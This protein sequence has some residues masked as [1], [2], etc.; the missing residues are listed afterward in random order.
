LLDR[1][2][3]LSGPIAS[4]K[5]TLANR[6]VERFGFVRLSS[7]NLILVLKP[8]VPQE[9]LA[10]QEAGD[11][12]DRETQGQWVRDALVRRVGQ[13]EQQHDP[14]FIVVD[15]I[16]TKEQA[17]GIRQAY[18]PQVFH[19]HL[20]APDTVLADRVS[21]RARDGDVSLEEAKKNQTESSVNE[22]ADIAD[23]VIETN[24]CVEED[25]LVRAAGHMGLYGRGLT[26]LVDVLVGGQYGSEGKGNVASYLAREYDLLI[27]VGG[28]NAGHKV[29]EE[30]EPYTFHLLPSG[31]RHNSEA[32]LLLAPGA[33][34]NVE[35]LLKEIAEC[36]VGADRLSIDPRC[37]LIE[38]ADRESEERVKN[39]IGS[40]A[41]GV[42]AA[43]A[44][45]IL[46]R[47]K[48]GVRLAADEPL[49]KP[50]IRDA[51]EVL[52]DAFSN[53][54]RVLLEGT[55]GSGLS[56]YHGFYP[57]VTS[58]DTTV[59]GCLAEAGIAPSRVRR[60]ILVCRT[61]PIRVESPAGRTSGPM[62][63]ETSWDE[64][65]RRAGIDEAHLRRVERTSTT[66]RDRRVSEFDWALFRRAVTL[67]GPT[68]IALT[69]VDYIAG[70]NQ[71]ARRF[72]QL[73]PETIRFIEEV[74]K[75]AAAPV[76][77]IS[78][79]FHNRCIIDRR[80]W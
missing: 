23:A 57:H 73:T 67:N 4:G 15:S 12:L 78:T 9:R 44:R 13:L 8:D 79:R 74:E 31:T 72:D 5:S 22:L 77:L 54:E 61:F 66:N 50:F 17:E 75:I 40:T 65:A 18:G 11:Q 59:S 64:V 37:M 52:D 43:T 24:R 33:V 19:I 14:L 41:Q 3:I 70:Q 60:T 49:L 47:G 35:I 58:R 45:R 68:D 26:Q 32:K 69:F 42:G 62:S 48:P 39:D 6:L 56:L 7:S 34:L 55:Q 46:D 20:M 25:V 63:L 38:P 51:S 2:L 10:L 30:P 29:Y 53:S 36:G 16:R 21:D 1:I 76:S 27:R 28:P 71:D 80:A